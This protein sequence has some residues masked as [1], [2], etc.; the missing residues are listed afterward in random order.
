MKKLIC[1]LLLAVILVSCGKKN[2][3]GDTSRFRPANGGK[4][5]GGTFRDNEV[6]EMR[7]LDPVGINDATSTHIGENV[8]D[9]LIEFDADL[10][11]QPSLAER[12]EVSPDGL[13]YTFYLRK[14]VFF[15]DN[16]CF[17]GGKGREF[18]A[19]DV[20]YSFSRICDARARSLGFDYFRG[21]VVGADEYYKATQDAIGK[22]NTAGLDGVKGFVAVGKY[23]FQVKLTRPF[24]PLEKY[25]ALSVC[26]I[27]PREAVEYYKE[28]FFKNP[29]GTGPFKF[30]SWKPEQELIMVRNP[31]YWRKDEQG[32]QLPYL[33]TIKF[34]FIKDEKTQL[35]EFKQGNL[36]EAYRIPGEFFPEIVDENK[37]PKGEYAKFKLLHLPALSTQYY[38]MLATSEVFKDKRVRQAF[39][40]AVDR[41]RIVK[42]VLKNQAAGAGVNGLVPPPMPDYHSEKIQGYSFNPEKAKQLLAEAG[43]P[44]GKGFP[45]VALQ[46]NQGGGRNVQVAEAIQQMLMDN[47]GIKV[48]MKQVEFARHLDEVDAGRSAFFRLGWVADYPDPENFLNLF[49]GKLV[50]ELTEKS[51]IN[52]VRYNNPAF[53]VLFEQALA[54]QDAAKRLE[55][56]HKAEQLA[57]D[58][59][60]MLLIYYD[61]DFRFIQP[62]V[63]DY[64][65]NSMDRR[66]YKFIW[67]NPAKMK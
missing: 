16:P 54:T 36:D 22:P 40:Y 8:Y 67:L 48:E 7:S 61:E 39:S 6:S 31:N 3:N 9:N 34:T 44:N 49:Y 59:A 46:L 51:P 47:L 45:S 64:R 26:M 65:N 10:H 14:G 62:F 27:H 12:W 29:V 55:L 66:P 57:M 13:T 52:Q 21:K 50:P 60:P 35:L 24:S 18:T 37:N 30:V 5:Y 53:D 4:F 17:A 19:E 32:N 42:F 15:Q 56:F 63:E 23:T 41:E 2:G 11:I 58:D 1:F 28:D 43:F 20:R 33:D 38:G 25:P